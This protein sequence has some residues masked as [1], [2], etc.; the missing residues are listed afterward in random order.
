MSAPTF[1]TKLSAGSAGHSS[2]VDAMFAVSAWTRRDSFS[3]WECITQRI[4]MQLAVGSMHQQLQARFHAP[5]VAP[6]SSA[7]NHA[8]VTCT[9]ANIHQVSESQLRHRKLHSRYVITFTLTPLT[10]HNARVGQS[11]IR[12]VGAWYMH[13]GFEVVHN[14]RKPARTVTLS[15]SH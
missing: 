1:I 7:A 10:L 3:G 11:T 15:S 9:R 6:L 2:A 5:I 14:T 12:V 4:R 13:E 8:S